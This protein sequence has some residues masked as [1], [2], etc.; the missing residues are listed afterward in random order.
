MTTF[1]CD[2]TSKY[3]VFVLSVYGYNHKNYGSNAVFMAC[4]LNEANP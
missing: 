1:I 3:S 4:Y 2:Y